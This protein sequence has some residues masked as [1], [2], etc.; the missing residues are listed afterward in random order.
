MFLPAITYYGTV[1]APDPWKKS[2]SGSL[3]LIQQHRIR[4]PDVDPPHCK[5]LLKARTNM[6]KKYSLVPE[7]TFGRWKAEV[8]VAPPGVLLLLVRVCSD[9]RFDEQRPLHTVLEGYLNMGHSYCCGSSAEQ[10]TF[11]VPA[12]KFKGTTTAK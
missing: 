8:S 6:L 12:G 10:T 2:E 11:P 3:K 5:S 4:I 7:L 9:L 1:S